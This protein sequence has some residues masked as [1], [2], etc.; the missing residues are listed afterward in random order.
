[1]ADDRGLAVPASLSVAFPRTDGTADY[2]L[3]YTLASLPLAGTAAAGWLG[4]A[5]RPES[6]T[7]HSAAAYDGTNASELATLA[8]QL[9]VDWLGWRRGRAHLALIGC[10]PWQP[11]GHSDVEWEASNELVCTR[12]RSV[13]LGPGGALLAPALGGTPYY[14]TPGT[15]GSGSSGTGGGGGGGSSSGATVYYQSSSAGSLFPS[16]SS[17]GGTITGHTVYL[18]GSTLEICGRLVT[19]SASSVTITT[20]QNNYTPAVFATVLPLNVTTS[21]SLT[22]LVPPDVTHEYTTTLVNTGTATLTVTNQDSGSSANYRFTTTTGGSIR[23]FPGATLKVTYDPT[24]LTWRV[25]EGTSTA[26]D[27]TPGTASFSTTRTDY[28]IPTPTPQQYWNIT[29]TPDITG[30]ALTAGLRRFTATNTGSGTATIKNDATSAS[31]NRIYTPDGGDLAFGPGQTVTFTYDDAVSRWRVSEGTAVAYAAASASGVPST[32]PTTVTLTA[33]PTWFLVKEITHADLTDADHSQ[34]ITAY[35][36]PA[37]AAIHAGFVRTKT[38]GSGGGVT[39]LTTS[40]V[41]AATLLTAGV[42]NGLAANDVVGAFTAK[43][44]GGGYQLVQS[45]TGTTTI[46]VR[47]DADVNVADL[48][49]GQWD[50]YLLLSTAG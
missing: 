12:A 7:L 47:F 17:A 30:F 23:V 14:G 22:G 46:A 20:T 10:V 31:A 3:T 37:K 48:T 19:C 28:A 50:C 6:V 34:D 4:T 41:V 35:T 8:Q 2:T 24:A 49:G 42:G 29:S 27:N 5:G 32:P 11:D 16:S 33:V 36:L 39:V 15:G 44:I 18:P 45:W 1:M 38:A 13:P 9:L 21:S 26:Y 25:F 43:E 40:W